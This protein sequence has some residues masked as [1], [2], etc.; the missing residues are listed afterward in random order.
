M[1][2]DASTREEYF[3]AAGDREPALRELDAIIQ[4]AA[5]HL[6]PTYLKTDYMTM[7]GYG[8]MPYKTKS[9]KEPGEWPLIA[10][11]YQKNHMS[12][13]VCAVEKDGSYIAENLE[14]Q[15]GKVSCGKSCIRFK[16]LEDLNLETVRTMLEDLDKR[17]QSGEKLYGA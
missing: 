3:A 10:L 17:Y 12:M 11:A 1:K 9:M 13:Y 16:K 15:L 7:L 6:K 8:M 5:P 4:G 2:V 14:P